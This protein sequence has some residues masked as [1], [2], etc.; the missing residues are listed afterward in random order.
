MRNAILALLATTISVYPWSAL[1]ER[2]S[3]RFKE[4]EWDWLPGD[5]VFRNN[6]NAFDEIVRENESGKWA[7]VGVIRL[8]SGGPMVVF[9]DEKEGVKETLLDN[10]IDGEAYAAYRIDGLDD[11][12]S[13]SYDAG[14]MAAGRYYGHAYDSDL[15]FENGKLYNA[16]LPFAAALNAGVLLTTPKPLREITTPGA[17]LG[18][19][20]LEHR[21]GQFPCVEADDLEMCWEWLQDVAIVTP[22]SILSSPELQQVYP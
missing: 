20:L 6:L 19:A 7:S 17:P 15:I 4:A 18:K 11:L 16:E 21:I 22:G 3:E 13:N 12:R 1:A 5:L 9:V 10:F 8:S 2:E 14:P